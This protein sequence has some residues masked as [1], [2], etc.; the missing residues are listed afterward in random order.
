LGPL[1]VIFSPL[2]ATVTPGGTVMGILP[3]RDIFKSYQT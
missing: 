3:I 2:M 1:T